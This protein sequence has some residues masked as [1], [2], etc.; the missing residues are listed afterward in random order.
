LK[1]SHKSE[2]FLNEGINYIPY[3]LAL[4]IPKNILIKNFSQVTNHTDTMKFLR[5]GTDSL[6]KDIVYDFL[7]ADNSYDPKFYNTSGN[8]LPQ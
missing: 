1:N 7:H 5:Y 3:L 2:E 8:I 4:G 6:I